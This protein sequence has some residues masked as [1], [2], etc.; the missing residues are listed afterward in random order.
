MVFFLEIKEWWNITIECSIDASWRRQSKRDNLCKS[1]V[2]LRTFKLHYEQDQ[3]SKIEIEIIVTLART[4]EQ[5]ASRFKPLI[6]ITYPAANLS[7]PSKDRKTKKKWFRSVLC[8]SR[9]KRRIFTYFCLSSSE[10]PI[11]RTIDD[12]NIANNK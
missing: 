11:P 9:K 6:V 5:I 12:T 4:N 7:K 8:S 3:W 1:F 2:D 10:V